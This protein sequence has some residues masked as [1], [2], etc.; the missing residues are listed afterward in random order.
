MQYVN[1]L[2][3]LLVFFLAAK[4]G[5]NAQSISGIIIDSLSGHLLSNATVTV[6]KDGTEITTLNADKGSFRFS[7][8]DS[9]AAYEVKI[10]Y[11]GYRIET[12]NP[13]RPS[14]TVLSVYLVREQKEMAG[15]TVSSA[16]PFILQKNDRITVNV[17]QSPIVAGGNAYDAVKKAPGVTDFQN[18]QFRGKN[19]TVYIN[20]KPARLGGE[21]LKNYLSSM[22]ANTVERVEVIP[23]PSAKYE[24][25]GGPVINIILAKSKDLGTNGIL[26]TGAGAGRYPRLNSGLSVNHRTADLNIYGSYDLLQN[27]T[28]SVIRADRSFN[29]LFSVSDEQRSFDELQSH[30]AK[31]GLDYTI[32]KR[33]SAGVLVRGVFTDKNKFSKNMSE[34]TRDS[35]SLVTSEG[36]SDVSTIA[37]NVYYKTKIGKTGDLSVNADYFDYGKTRKDQF[38]TRYYD[39]KQ[40]EYAAPYRL[41]ASA[42]ADNKIGS[43]S[44]DYLFSAGKIRYEAGAKAVMTRTDNTSDWEKNANGS[45]EDDVQR[46]NRFIYKENVYAAYVSASGSKG[47]FDVEAGLRMEYTDAS[48]HSVTLKQENSNDYISLFPS[49]T[50]SFNESE[51]QQYSFSYRRRIERFGFDI[52]NP[53]IVY[54]NQY[55]FYQGNPFIKPSFSDNLSLGWTYGNEWMASIDYGHFTDALA[56][57][58]KKAGN[59]E[60]MISTFENIASAD[61]LSLNVSYTKSLFN[62]KLTTSNTLGGLYA[63]YN[64]PAGTDLS[65]AALAVFLSSSNMV[66][67]GKIWRGELSAAYYS[68]MQ[69]GAYQFRSQFFASLGFSRTLLDKKATLGVSLTD[70]FNSNKQRYNVSSYGVQSVNKSMPETR[71]IKLNFTY[72]FGNKNVKAAKNRQTGIDEMKKRMSN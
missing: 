14:N 4:S 1:K 30:S 29:P 42:P 44:A 39:A 19:V 8:L 62:G 64:A 60:A 20:D 6:S 49:L 31:A 28:R 22:P 47:K 68:P 48:G 32:N 5:A 55:A 24:A 17:S 46:S 58:Y 66:S 21:E 61:Q 54:Q 23:N 53:F 15:V 40:S 57:V 36:Q 69:F 37:T 18:L 16:K 71:F 34:T 67:I 13:V 35:S 56:E 12:L 25:N 7:G 41:R 11:S 3:L 65:N 2:I 33:S 43:F 70:I 63:K 51:K 72:R 10:R 52:V 9:S 38:T 26:T 59:G 45:W 27:K 50:V